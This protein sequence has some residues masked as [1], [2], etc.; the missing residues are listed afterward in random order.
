MLAACVA[1]ILL[2]GSIFHVTTTIMETAST[3]SHTYELIGSI[4][5][6]ATRSG[7]Y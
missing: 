3:V 6:T 4:K 5:K 7:R 1:A 2:T